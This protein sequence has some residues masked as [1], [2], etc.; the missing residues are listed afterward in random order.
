M[1]ATPATVKATAT[2][3]MSSTTTR[4]VGEICG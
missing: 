2:T 3:T 4:G 1:K